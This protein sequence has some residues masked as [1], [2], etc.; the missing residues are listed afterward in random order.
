M[1]QPSGWKSIN[2]HTHIKSSKEQRETLR[3]STSNI[4]KFKEIF[5]DFKEI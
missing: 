5:F 3:R 4:E 1:S 2:T